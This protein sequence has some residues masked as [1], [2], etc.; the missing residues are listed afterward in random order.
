MSDRRREAISRLPYEV[1]EHTADAGIIA[2][3]AELAELFANAG[4]GMLSL[5][6]DLEGVEP[7]EERRIEVEAR[8]REGLLVRWLTELLYYLD[9]EEML[10]RRFEMGEVSETRLRARGFGERIDRGRHRL[11]FGVKAVTRH[12]LEVRQEDGGYRATVLF[13]I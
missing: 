1:L 13:D 8:D 11:H 7:K 3:G 12:L 2:R 10:F 5:M 6:V 4:L 9:A